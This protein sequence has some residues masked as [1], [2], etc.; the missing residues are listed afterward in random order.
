MSLRRKI[1]CWVSM[2]CF[3]Y[4]LYLMRKEAPLEMKYTG[5]ANTF[6]LYLLVSPTVVICILLALWMLVLH[7]W[8]SDKDR[9]LKVF[10]YAGLVFL[11]LGYGVPILITSL[12]MSELS[13]SY[14]VVYSELIC[15]MKVIDMGC[16]VLSGL[17]YVLPLMS[18]KIRNNTV[19]QVV[20]N[21][22]MGGIGLFV[23]F[24]KTVP[25]NAWYFSI[26][27][28]CAA[29][30]IGCTILAHGKVTEK[31]ISEWDNMIEGGE[32]DE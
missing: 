18:V 32:T 12:K 20:M 19:F 10:Q 25:Y 11:G 2:I 21:T 3:Y 22:I 27:A 13:F 1:T 15:L 26:S 8:L 5:S 29:F 7:I 17:I 6:S 9:L 14:P 4:I 31:E 24:F 16:L 28:V 23:I 30:A